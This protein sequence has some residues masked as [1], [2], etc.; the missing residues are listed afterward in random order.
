MD[1]AGAGEVRLTVLP[2]Q[3]EIVFPL[4]LGESSTQSDTVSHLSI[5]CDPIC[6]SGLS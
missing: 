2:V 3:L 6:S 5:S 4:P 1:L